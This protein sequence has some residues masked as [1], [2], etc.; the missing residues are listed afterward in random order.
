MNPIKQNYAVI[1][2]IPDDEI[3]CFVYRNTTHAEAVDQFI[4]D[5]WEGHDPEARERTRKLHGTDA[6][7][8]QVLVSD[9]PIYHAHPFYD[10]PQT[11]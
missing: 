4:E 6:F 5:L 9:T 10:V 1:G 7:I 3:Y 11:S 8:D 2:R